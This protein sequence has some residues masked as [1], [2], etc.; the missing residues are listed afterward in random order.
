MYS[1]SVGSISSGVFGYPALHLSL[2]TCEWE[3]IFT[4]AQ[5]ILHKCLLGCHAAR[6]CAEVLSGKED[7]KLLNDVRIHS[8]GYTGA[9]ANPS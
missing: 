1:C 2:K 5:S 4:L 9:G 8:C 6:T 3:H 7:N